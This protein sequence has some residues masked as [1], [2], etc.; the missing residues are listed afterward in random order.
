MDFSTLATSVPGTYPC[1]VP[2]MSF[3]VR[4]R[5]FCSIFLML[6]A[7]FGR[8]KGEKDKLAGMFGSG[9]SSAKDRFANLA[10]SM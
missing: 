10:K 7:E 8:R 9:A 6:K 5:V 1:P 3:N 4:W 2:G